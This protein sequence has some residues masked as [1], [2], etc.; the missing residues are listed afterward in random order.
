MTTVRTSASRTLSRHSF[1]AG[2]GNE[3]PQT[4]H[5]HSTLGSVGAESSQTSDLPTLRPV[6]VPP[7]YPRLNAKPYI[8]NDACLLAILVYNSVVLAGLCLLCFKTGTRREFHSSYPDIGAMVRYAPSLIGTITTVLARSVSYADA[9]IS[10]YIAMA[11]ETSTRVRSR[12]ATGIRSVDAN[13]VLPP[14]LFLPPPLLWLLGLIFRRSPG[15]MDTGTWAI[16]WVTALKAVLLTVSPTAS[17]SLRGHE[18]KVIY[19]VGRQGRSE[20]DNAVTACDREIH[21]A[22]CG[23]PQDHHISGIRTPYATTLLIPKWQL[24]PPT[25]LTSVALI[26]SVGF[27]DKIRQENS[28][29]LGQLLSQILYDLRVWKYLTSLSG[30][31]VN[32]VARIILVGVASVISGVWI[33]NLDLQMRISQP[34]VNMYKEDTSVDDSLLLDYLWGLPGAVTYAALANKHWIVAWFSVL[35]LVGPTFPVLVAGFVIIEKEEDDNKQVIFNGNYN[36]LSLSLMIGFLIAFWISLV[37]AFFS[38][39]HRRLPRRCLSLADIMSFFYASKIMQNRALDISS[40]TA[41]KRH[42]ESRLFLQEQRFQTG[43][44]TGVDGKRH[45]GVDVKW[46][47]D[48]HRSR[49]HVAAVGRIEKCDKGCKVFEEAESPILDP[50]PFLLLPLHRKLPARS[51]STI[52][53]RMRLWGRNL[54]LRLSKEGTQTEEK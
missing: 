1:N 47:H 33:V 38:R 10:P 8:L 34:F 31:A 14:A 36:G 40:K 24:L 50:L 21:R 44:F 43:L 28:S 51:P 49:R 53:A 39:Q 32:V 27:L 54:M 13:M 29:G 17:G 5:D 6:P 22:F 2:D 9:R 15:V 20:E 46:N 12:H 19:G 3:I 35:S 18:S 45:F 30:N 48:D 25:L 23:C 26:V 37:I 41:T 7:G 11:D 4:H 16:A 52:M 42:L